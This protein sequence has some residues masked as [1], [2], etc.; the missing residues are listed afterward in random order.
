M[1][2]SDSLTRAQ[3]G[4]HRR[5]TAQAQFAPSYITE[6]TPSDGSCPEDDSEA[7]HEYYNAPLLGADAVD[8][9]EV[10]TLVAVARAKGIPV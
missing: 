1:T 10:P 2:S 4:L 9:G 6:H 3:D 7:Q 8:Q 5:D